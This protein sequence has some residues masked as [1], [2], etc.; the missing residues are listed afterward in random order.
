MQPITLII[1]LLTLLLTFSAH[2]AGPIRTFLGGPCTPLKSNPDICREANERWLVMKSDRSGTKV[3]GFVKT[4]PGKKKLK[5]ASRSFGFRGK[6]IKRDKKYYQ[7]KNAWGLIETNG[8]KPIEPPIYRQIIPISDQYALA[9][10]HDLHSVYDSPYYLVP[11]DG[12]TTKLGKPVGKKNILY[13]VGGYS[14]QNPIKVFVNRGRSEMSPNKNTHNIEQLGPDGKLVASYDNIIVTDAKLTFFTQDET[15]L[16]FAKGIDPKTGHEVSMRWGPMGD[17]LGY[18]P[19]VDF[20]ETFYDLGR[21]KSRSYLMQAIGRLPIKTDLPNQTIYLPLDANGEPVTGPDNFIGMTPLYDNK[22]YYDTKIQKHKD[23]LL[24]YQ[25]P[26][27]FSY[28]IAGVASK[29]VGKNSVHSPISILASEADYVMLA[30]FDYR[31]EFRNLDLPY[32][33]H[34]WDSNFIQFYSAYEADGVTPKPNAYPKNWHIFPNYHRRHN[35][36]NVD[37]KVY[38]SK[39]QGPNKKGWKEKYSAIQYSYQDTLDFRADQ[40]E[41]KR[42][43]EQRIAEA[44]QRRDEEYKLAMEAAQREWQEQQA[45]LAAH[46][47]QNQKS[48]SEKFAQ[49]LNAWGESMRKQSQQNNNNRNSGYR[50]ECYNNYDGTETCYTSKK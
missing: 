6:M 35:V 20:I 49:G 45:Y 31:R 3:I 21:E 44:R 28:K 33:K 16:V 23:W 19:K 38:Y 47:K 17:F 26:N 41:R 13:F 36:L 10:P 18:F 22:W 7:S 4:Q 27:G 42:A 37:E 32:I 29:P 43:H 1:S 2:A 15:G 25:T 50:T 8:D 39:I 40:L 11:I 12:K 9:Q 46:P 48:W 5:K 24:I 14:M 34:I 30:G